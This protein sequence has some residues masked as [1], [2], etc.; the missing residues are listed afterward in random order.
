MRPVL[1]RPAQQLGG[2]FGLRLGGVG[3]SRKHGMKCCAG[4]RVP[5]AGCRVP[6]AGCRVPDAQWRMAD[7]GCRVAG[8]GWRVPSG[9]V[10]GFGCCQ[11]SILA[12]EKPDWVSMAGNVARRPSS[13]WMCPG[14]SIFDCPASPV[15]READHPPR[16]SRG[17]AS[18][19]RLAHKRC[20]PACWIGRQGRYQFGSSATWS[21][22]GASISTGSPH[23]V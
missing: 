22:G 3:R 9:T 7:G 18:T 6:G 10:A 23:F 11:F 14:P 2:G 4:C 17:R 16:R 21:A 5:G 12:A 15:G 13:A 8:A 19:S 1:R 20:A